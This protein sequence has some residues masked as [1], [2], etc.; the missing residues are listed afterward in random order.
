[1]T[2]HFGLNNLLY[3]WCLFFS[4]DLGGFMNMRVFLSTVVLTAFVATPSS[5]LFADGLPWVMKNTSGADLASYVS[6]QF[7]TNLASSTNQQFIKNIQ[8]EVGMDNYTVDIRKMNENAVSQLGYM[9]A[10][11]FEIS[12]FHGILYI[13]EQWFNELSVEE[14]RFVIGHEF[15]H[16][17]Y[18]HYPAVKQTGE[19]IIHNIVGYLDSV[20]SNNQCVHKNKLKEI[21][22]DNLQSLLNQALIRSFEHDADIFAIEKLNCKKGGWE[23]CE[24]WQVRDILQHMAVIATEGAPKKYDNKLPCCCFDTH[25]LHH[26]RI[27]YMN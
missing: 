6:Q 7:G 12:D 20:E 9:N 19:T 1:M 8:H 14:K 26:A 5:I 15:G 17:F 25:P 27:I 23:V 18:G 3:K 22:Y 10:Y 16:L 24:R 4:Y 2:C 11:M 21:G 13:S